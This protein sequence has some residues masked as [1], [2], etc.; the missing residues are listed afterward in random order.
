MKRPCLTFSFALVLFAGVCFGQ[1]TNGVGTGTSTSGAG[2]ASIAAGTQISGQLQNSLDART[3][4]VGDEVILKTTKAVKYNGSMVVRKGALLIGHVSDVSTRTKADASSSVAIVFDKL[5]QDGREIAITGMITSVTS[6]SVYRSN[7]AESSDQGYG[8]RSKQASPRPAATNGGVIGG[9][10]NSVG[11]VVNATTQ[12]AGNVVGTVD[13]TL[14]G[15]VG[16]SS[17]SVGMGVSGVSISQSAD[18]AANG[19]S[20]LTLTGRDRKLEKGTSFDVKVSSSTKVE[21]R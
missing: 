12:S 1:G 20:I 19:G 3:A 18:A 10:T 2:S 5:R 4:K 6:A 13:G 11:G 15:V 14:G 9:V 16:E 7:G 17:G 21:L 8:S